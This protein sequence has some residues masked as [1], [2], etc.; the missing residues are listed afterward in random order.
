MV[1]G[2]VLSV[3]EFAVLLTYLLN[4]PFKTGNYYSND[5]W[6]FWKQVSTVLSCGL[7]NGSS[8]SL[9]QTS[10]YA[11]D[12]KYCCPGL[13]LTATRFK[14]S[15][16]AETTPKTKFSVSTSLD[17]SQEHKSY[18]QIALKGLPFMYYAEYCKD[19]TLVEIAIC[20]IMFGNTQV[21]RLQLRLESLNR[22]QSGQIS[23]FH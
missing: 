20:D 6:W 17:V 13:E 22:G 19:Y 16:E 21:E 3:S 14:K 5:E 15:D 1:E 11:A 23:P 10:D 2:T 18:I 7:N 8:F 12:F 9:N 4:T